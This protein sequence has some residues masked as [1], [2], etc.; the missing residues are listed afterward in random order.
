MQFEIA[1]K[2]KGVA[3]IVARK[4]DKIGHAETGIGRLLRPVSGVED[5]E[6]IAEGE[7]ARQID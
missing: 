6:A 7:I 4:N 2:I 3:E 1:N 5:G